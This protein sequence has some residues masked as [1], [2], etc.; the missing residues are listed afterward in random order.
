LIEAIFFD[1]GGVI[2][3]TFDGADHDLIEKEFGLEPGTLRR[4][5]FE[6]SRWPESE[7]GGCTVEELMA[8]I[9]EA[10]KRRV[11]ERAGTILRAYRDADRALNIDMV[12]LA[13]RLHG[14]YKLGII[15]NT[16]PGFKEQLRRWTGVGI[17]DL[18]D[19]RVGSG[20]LG[21]AKPDA[22]I[23]LHATKLAGVAPEQSVFTD[24]R[25]DFAEAARS[26]R[27]AGV[28]LHE[29]RAVRGGPAVGGGGGGVSCRI[30]VR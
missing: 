29:V 9:L 8:S 26:G 1:F 2:L 22:G 12:A 17:V 11:G 4:C 6:D 7:T 27:D 23:F 21:I 10:M 15:S 30:S 13:K 24:D 5:I 19:V 18:F 20:D 14:R 16:I 25:A 28:S 3:K